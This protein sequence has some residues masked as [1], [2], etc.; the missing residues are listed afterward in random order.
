ME[1]LFIL[2][3]QGNIVFS[4]NDSVEDTFQTLVV[5]IPE[6]KY[7]ERFELKEGGFVPVFKDIPKDELKELKEKLEYQ[8]AV[9]S[10]LEV[11][12]IDVVKMIVGE[13]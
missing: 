3:S 13:E 1:T 6:G 12:L 7:L 8:E 10:E 4:K 11:A 5:D 2:N 9:T